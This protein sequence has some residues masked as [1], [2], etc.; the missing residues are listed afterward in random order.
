MSKCHV[1]FWVFVSLK[2]EGYEPSIGASKTRSHQ[3]VQMASSGATF[4]GNIYF[5]RSLLEDR[6]VYL[7]ST[8]FCLLLAPKTVTHK[9][10][11]CSSPSMVST[12]LRPYFFFHAFN[13][14]SSNVR[15]IRKI[16]QM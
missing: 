3:W 9:P 13:Q 7:L 6:N 4:L 14:D 8:C 11:T 1:S 2:L 10:G 15:E 16:L 12:A 5:L